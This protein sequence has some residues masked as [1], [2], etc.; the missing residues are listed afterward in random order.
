[1]FSLGFIL[2]KNKRIQFGALLNAIFISFHGIILS[3]YSGIYKFK[4]AKKTGLKGNCK[5]KE[6]AFIYILNTEAQKQ[7]EP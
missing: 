1:M 3:R 5:Y 6:A 4:T 7:N 2:S